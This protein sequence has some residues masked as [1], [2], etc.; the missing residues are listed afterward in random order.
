MCDGAC[1]CTHMTH[2]T[3]LRAQCNNHAHICTD[4]C[5]HTSRT[6]DHSKQHTH[7]HPHTHMRAQEQAHSRVSDRAPQA[8]ANKSSMQKPPKHT[9]SPLKT[10]H[11]AGTHARTNAHTHAY[12]NPHPQTHTHP[13]T[14]RDPH[15]HPQT[16]LHTR[17]MRQT[18]YS[19]RW[20]ECTRSRQVQSRTKTGCPACTRRL[21]AT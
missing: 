3:R 12:A 6:A 15:I 14:P 2:V 13:H 16:H 4:T 17:S 19:K 5:V 20:P 8:S 9:L 1:T 11:I 21:S 7:T 10:V 18:G